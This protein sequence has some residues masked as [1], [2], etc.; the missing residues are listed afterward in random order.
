M[1]IKKFGSRLTPL[2][3]IIGTVNSAQ[4]KAP[5]I[6]STILSHTIK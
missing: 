5:K 4:P 2:R 3:K 1:A 6:P